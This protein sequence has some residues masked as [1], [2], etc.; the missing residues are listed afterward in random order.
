MDY[1]TPDV[2]YNCLH[3]LQIDVIKPVSAIPT[4]NDAGQPWAKIATISATA[5]WVLHGSRLNNV[6]ITEVES[7]KNVY[8]AGT[9][10]KSKCLLLES[11][12]LVKAKVTAQVVNVSL[13]GYFQTCTKG[14]KDICRKWEERGYKA[15][16]HLQLL[17]APMTVIS[18]ASA[19]DLCP[20]RAP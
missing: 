17:P 14:Y 2:F 5:P 12:S 15:L 13:G 16:V 9:Q 3:L 19:P 6:Q 18:Q 4:E 11:W 1:L 8:M 20:A 10:T 7:R